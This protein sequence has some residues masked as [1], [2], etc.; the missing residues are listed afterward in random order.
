[1]DGAIEDR[2]PVSISVNGESCAAWDPFALSEPETQTLPAY[3]F[4]L[5]V[6][7]IELSTF[8]TPTAI[9]ELCHRSGT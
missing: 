2:S 7:E 4:D 5:D 1:M 8:E 6:E 9:A 3:D